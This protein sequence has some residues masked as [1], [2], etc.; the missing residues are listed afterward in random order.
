MTDIAD[1]AGSVASGLFLAGVVLLPVMQVRVGIGAVD[2][3]AADLAFMLA[4]V[5]TLVAVAAGRLRVKRTLFAAT[6]MG[7][8]GAVVIALLAGGMTRTTLS[9]AA[10][11][12]YVTG[13]A[14]LGH[15]LVP[16][17]VVPERFLRAFVAGTAVAVGAVLVGIVLFYA[18]L[19]L[20]RENRFVGAYGAVPSGRYPRVIGT[21][22]NPN[23]LCNFLVCGLVAGLTAGRLG[24]ISR[25]LSAALVPATLVAVGFTLSPGIGGALLAAGVWLWAFPALRSH[26][27]RRAALVAGVA[28]AVAFLVLTTVKLDLDDG[29]QRSHRVRAWEDAGERFVDHPIVGVG[30]D[31]N[32][33]HVEHGND[34]VTDAHNMWL[35]VAGQMG[36]IGVAAIGAVFVAPF[37]DAERRRRIWRQPL[38]GGL[39]VALLGALAYHGLSMSVEDARHLWIVLGVLAGLA[40]ADSEVID[41][42]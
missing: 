17:A 23:L 5:A 33:A 12:V 14:A 8:A 10:A 24:V 38:A 6:L 35:S 4:G 32:L 25:R 40:Y 31:E 9:G 37:A 2:L 29:V 27:F 16:H 11:G 3:V 41:V 19:E 21:F 30:L 34:L 15:Q 1:R 39:A 7:Y 22:V 26:A 18:G 36:V 42:S 20:P 28:G 13:L